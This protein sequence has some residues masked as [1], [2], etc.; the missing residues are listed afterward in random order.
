MTPL[1]DQDCELVAWLDEGYLLGPEGNW[2]AF[3]SDGSFWSAAIPTRW[4]GPLQAGCGFDR[5]GKPVVWQEGIG[6]FGMQRPLTPAMPERPL[7]ARPWPPRSPL[8][9]WSPQG[10]A[11]WMSGTA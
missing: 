11:A 6:W 7:P 3:L 1:F 10:F 4:V 5:D 9:G 8:G 2:L